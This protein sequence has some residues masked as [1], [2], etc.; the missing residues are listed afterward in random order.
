MD[1]LIGRE[2]E[3]QELDEA[4]HSNRSELILLRGRRR[5]GKT[6]LIRSYFQDQYTFH[7]VGRFKKSKKDQLEAFRYELQL[8]SGVSDIPE[9]ICWKDAFRALENY[10]EQSQDVRKVIFLDEIPWMDRHGNELIQELDDF[11]NTWVTNRDDVVLI[12]CGSAT[13]W[14]RK[15]FEK[16]KGG[17]HRRITHKIYL[18]PFYLCEV[19]AY[20]EDHH[21]DWDDYQIMQ[22]YMIL[23]GVPYYLSLLKPYLSLPENI[24]NLIFRRGG[25]LEDEFDELFPALFFK[26]EKYVQTIRLLSKKREG[27][28]RQEIEKAIK[29][30][31]GTLTTLL[32]NL[33]DCD[34]ISRYS[35]LENKERDMLFR[36]S[37][38]YLLFYFQYIDN[39]RSKDEQ[40]W[41]HHFNDRSVE[42]WEGFAFEALCLLH[43]PLIKKGLGISGM[44]TSASSWRYAGDKENGRKGAQIDLI[45]KRADG[46]SHLVEMKFARSEY[47]IT[48]DYVQRLNER[49][50]TFSAV[51]GISHGLM[52]TFVTPLGIKRGVNSSGIVSQITGKDL[53]GL[54]L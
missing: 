43:L 48:K 29:V 14:M 19:K 17:L 54:L 37:D 33:E 3:W 34:F 31:G 38:M 24:D 46:L 39:N 41:L 10:L 12:A 26:S 6:F 15:K 32:E 49:R 21:I 35:Q 44:A 25:E 7:F 8:A 27:Y 40:Y 4:F 5:V 23:G 9:F 53:F 18:R 20:L 13:A 51:T 1:K 28:T 11:W 47:E 52:D 30:S 36:L 2:R 16:N 50:N 45:I 22:C 42:S